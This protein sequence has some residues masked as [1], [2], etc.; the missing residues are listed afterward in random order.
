[1]MRTVEKIM[2][3]MRWNKN[4]KEERKKTFILQK[5]T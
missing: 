4:E 2:R 1:M 3:Q 5:I